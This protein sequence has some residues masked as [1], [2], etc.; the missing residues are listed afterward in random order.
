MALQTAFT[1]LKDGG[2][3]VVAE[4]GKGH[5]EAEASVQAVEIYDVNEK[6]MPPTKVIRMARKTGFKRWRVKPNHGQLLTLLNGTNLSERKGL[7]GSIVKLP[8]TR[9]LVAAALILGVK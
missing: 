4:P 2:V 1:A 5:H 7:V 3:C 9:P 6:E 8:I